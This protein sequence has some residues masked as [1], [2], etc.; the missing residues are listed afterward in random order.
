MKAVDGL[1]DQEVEQFSHHSYVQKWFFC[2]VFHDFRAGAAPFVRWPMCLLKK[3]F[4][5]L[6]FV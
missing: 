1:V 6:Q 4:L 3:K 2:P 5:G